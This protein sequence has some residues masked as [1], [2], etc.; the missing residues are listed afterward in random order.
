MNRSLIVAVVSI[1]IGLGAGYLL[2]GG[3]QQ[4]A[5]PAAEISGG[6]AEPLF[7]RNPMNPAI[8][9]PTPAKDHMGM[10]YIPVYAGDGDRSAPVGTVKIDPVIRQNIGLRTAVAERKP[11][12]HTIR[13][14]GRV[15]Y[16]EHKLV[17]LHPKVEGWIDEI[18]IDKTGQL[19]AYDDILLNIYSPKLVATQQEYLLALKNFEALKGSSFEDIR[20]GASNLVASA[21]ERLVL[22]DV[23]G[24]QI[25]ELEQNRAIK[26]GLHIHAPAA[27]T[28]LEVGARQGQYV[29]P[30][31]QLYLI[32]DLST[33]WVYADI[34]EHELPWVAEGDRVEMTLAGVPGRSFSGRLDYVFPYAEE[35]TRTTKVRL[36]FDNPDRLL[37]PEMFADVVIFAAEKPDQVVVPSEAV[38]RSGDYNQLFVVNDA[39]EFEPRRVKLGVESRGEVSIASGLKAGERVVVS[40]Q[41]LVDSESSLRAATARMTDPGA[42][43]H[44]KMDHS[45]MDHSDMDHS[46]MNHSS[47]DDASMDHSGMDHSKMDHSSMD[48]PDETRH[49]EHRHD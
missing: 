10:D 44:S 38:V 46:G 29:T 26:E 28:L 49:E 11:M 32:A 5:A 42:M 27:G 3:G 12:S 9:S 48:D 41:F 14:P 25:H 36:V 24:H 37:R 4:Q 1:A 39:G 23:P 45:N 33:V 18:Y 17:R 35:K 47:T 34:Y 6:K 22:L 31:T 40:S 16:D 43:D 2:F 13:A 21:R 30:A 8:T 19:V 15:T 20:E 7:Y